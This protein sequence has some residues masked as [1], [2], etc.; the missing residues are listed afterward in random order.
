MKSSLGSEN[1]LSVKRIIFVALTAGGWI[2]YLI[3]NGHI[4][5]VM[6]L[7]GWNSCLSI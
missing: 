1:E 6:A 4:E 3:K 5:F 2:R 7:F